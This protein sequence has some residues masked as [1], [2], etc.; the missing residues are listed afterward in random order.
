MVPSLNATK[1]WPTAP[2]WQ[3]SVA[4]TFW[5]H[6]GGLW[7]FLSVLVWHTASTGWGVMKDGGNWR[8][9]SNP[10]RSRGRCWWHFCAVSQARDAG[11]LQTLTAV[12]LRQTV[13][14]KYCWISE[15]PGEAMWVCKLRRSI[16]RGL[17]EGLHTNC[18]VQAIRAR[19][20]GSRSHTY[21]PSETILLAW[22][23]L[24][25]LNDAQ[26]PFYMFL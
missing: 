14:Y 11:L 26:P 9:A 24:H 3:I 7:K 12:K 15:F 2:L 23:L 10:E 18:D 25:S 19:I 13:Y 21:G 6:L 8:S 5:K 17:A 1:M 4:H 22:Q 20:F 16:W